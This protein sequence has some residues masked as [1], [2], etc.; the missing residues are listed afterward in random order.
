MYYVLSRGMAKEPTFSVALNLRIDEAMSR[1]LK[2]IAHQHDTTESDA[3]R[4]LLRWG[5][6]AHRS[7]EATLL[8]RPYYVTDSEGP[9]RMRIRAVWE[10][11]DPEHETSGFETFW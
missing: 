1:E 11:Y 5:I 8:D 4:R 2:R 7:M 10:Q 6:E 9:Y 3:A